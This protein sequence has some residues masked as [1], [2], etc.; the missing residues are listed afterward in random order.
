MHGKHAQSAY[1]G[2]FE[3]VCDH[4]ILALDQPGDCPAARLRP[5]EVRSVSV[6]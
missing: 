5:G 1:T 6:A 4:A 2:H 3:S